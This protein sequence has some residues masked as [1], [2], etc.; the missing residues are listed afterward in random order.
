MVSTKSSWLSSPM[1]P[2]RRLKPTAVPF[3]TSPPNW[4]NLRSSGPSLL[5]VLTQAVE[6]AGTLH[7]TKQLA[8]VTSTSLTPSL[9]TE[10]KHIVEACGDKLRYTKQLAAVTLTS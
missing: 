6:A 2:M 7:C 3:C 9:L 1:E 5:T 8:A 4:V 10:L